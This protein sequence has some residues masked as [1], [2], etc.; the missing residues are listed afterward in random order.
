MTD[1]ATPAQP[2]LPAGPDWS[3]LPEDTA[4][5]DAGQLADARRQ[6]ITALVDR[7]VTYGVPGARQVARNWRLD[8]VPHVIDEATWS[9]LEPAVAQRA[10][11][12]DAVLADLYGPRRLLRDGT[13][14]PELVLADPMFLRTADGL[15]PA[16]HGLVLH[17]V[18]L[19][20]DPSGAWVA[21]QDRA[22]APSG[23]A[24]AMVDRRVVAQSLARLYRRTSIRR[25]G[26]FF[27]ALRRALDAAAP[28]G[29]EQ[30]QTV[31]LTPGPHSETAFDQAY[32]ATMLGVPLV[33]GTDLLVR[34]GQVW[35]EGMAGLEPV[36][37]ILRRVDGE[38][39]DPLDLRADSTL[40]LPGLVRAVR[41]GT[42]SVLNPL[43]SG[44]LEHPGLSA[45][46][47]R[48]ARAVLDED[49]AL[50]GP[51]TWW[52]GDSTARG[53]AL[54]H[55]DRLVLTYTGPGRRSRILGW[56]L[57]T[58]AREQLAARI[59]AEPLHW[60]AQELVTGAAVAEPASALRTFAVAD[61]EAYQVLAGGL[62]LVA[63][64]GE[65]LVSAERGAV[66]HDVWV[67]AVEPETGP[68]P[69][70]LGAGD[71]L[72]PR[73]AVALPPRTAENMFWLARYAERTGDTV[74]LMRATV[75][76]WY[77]HARR[78]ATPGGRALGVLL[79]ALG[80]SY[81]GGWPEPDPLAAAISGRRERRPVREL[82][83]GTEPGAVGWSV[84]RLA[85]AAA[86]VRDQMSN[87]FWLPI[88]SMERVLESERAA[89][90]APGSTTGL[91][92][93]LDRL[94]EA[95]LAVAGVAW[96]GMLRDPG[97]HLMDAG[98]RLERA[99]YLVESLEA[100]VTA[101]LPDE[102]ETFVLES[103][104][105]AHESSITYRRR[106]TAHPDVA[107]VLDLLVTD[108]ANPRSLAFQLDR[109]RSD[110][111]AVPSH[112]PTDRDRV[113]QDLVD[114]V[115]ELDPRSAAAVVGGRRDQLVEHL[116]SL[117]WRLRTLGDEI[118]RAHF[119]HRP[120]ARALGDPWGL[121]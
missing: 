80:A 76:R 100:T 21:V 108:E 81:P 3:W 28:A 83:L 48:V 86:A 50:P 6:T 27:H 38:W 37:V 26:P 68:D 87:D 121:S 15:V 94:L 11:V 115:R 104:L 47:P 49:L 30:P 57:D 116:E 117:R 75:D 25:I 63:P 95:L 42:V 90:R 33:E 39:C 119:A 107:N 23:A 67:I 106:H 18:D 109:L 13:L 91:V 45:Y 41:A 20:K 53:H 114:L 93:V 10:A 14:P 7:G 78:P 79:D 58:T 17:A 8:P 82:L 111:A 72:A 46:L 92:P 1:V 22:D 112:V 69:W 96:E 102:I 105:I 36:D 52:C 118:A 89:Q 88:A 5:P 9:D 120:S 97:W 56:T 71:E 35:L 31:L 59:G 24:Y 32:L 65:A 70:A 4:P 12:L 29:V 98:R 60:T 85:D 51:A 54:A 110:L 101:D 64:P 99:L 66:A 77:D 55:L 43:G 2:E 84:Q 44:V 19:S 62:A 113:A 73:R 103:L 40:G 74:R 34:D 61:G 16:R